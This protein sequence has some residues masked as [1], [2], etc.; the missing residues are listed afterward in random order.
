MHP[1][2]SGSRKARR[3]TATSAAPATTRYSSSTSSATS[4]AARLAGISARF[5][6][7]NLV[8]A[9]DEGVDGPVQL[10]QG[11]ARRGGRPA[12]DAGAT[13]EIKRLKAALK[14]GA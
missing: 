12:A 6:Q 11:Q 4:S 2:G 7:R 5:C 14:R 10:R 13:H 9:G 3:G 8:G 1:A